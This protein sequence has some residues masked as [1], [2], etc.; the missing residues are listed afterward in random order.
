M[1]KGLL[2]PTIDSIPK[3]RGVL[4][5]LSSINTGKT[6]PRHLTAEPLQAEKEGNTDSGLST[7]EKLVR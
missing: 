5:I 4:C 1:A 2:K 7:E 6:T 3:I